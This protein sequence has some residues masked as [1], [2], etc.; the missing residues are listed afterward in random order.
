MSYEENNPPDIELMRVY[1]ILN[2]ESQ[3]CD[4]NKASYMLI[5]PEIK[6]DLFVDEIGEKIYTVS[7]RNVNNFFRFA[8]RGCIIE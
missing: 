2:S 5:Y 3:Y 4:F 7:Y 8:V 6:I 1:E